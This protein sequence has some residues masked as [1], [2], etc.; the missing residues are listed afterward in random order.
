MPKILSKN[1]FRRI[2]WWHLVLGLILNILVIIV[3]FIIYHQ[4]TVTNSDAQQPAI[5]NMPTNNLLP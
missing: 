2:N 1:Q 4:V 3:A 5:K